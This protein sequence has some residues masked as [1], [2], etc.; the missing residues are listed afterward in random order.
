[1]T[2]EEFVEKLH[3]ISVSEEQIQIYIQDY[4][5]LKKAITEFTY[6][7]CFKLIDKIEK[8]PEEGLSV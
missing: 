7:E 1:V 2:R 4:E 8:E 3:E 5:R 6:E